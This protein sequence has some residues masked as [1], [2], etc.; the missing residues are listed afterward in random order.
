MQLPD[1]NCHELTRILLKYLSPRSRPMQSLDGE[2][3]FHAHW[4]WVC[5]FVFVPISEIR[6]APCQLLQPICQPHLGGYNS[7]NGL[8]EFDPGDRMT[9]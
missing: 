5:K 1:T 9:H 7:E 4:E 3:I 8:R 2:H 6:V